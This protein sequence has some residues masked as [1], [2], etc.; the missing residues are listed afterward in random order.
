MTL[1]EPAFVKRIEHDLNGYS[2]EANAILDLCLGKA[3]V[4]NGSG[5]IDFTLVAASGP[6]FAVRHLGPSVL[7]LQRGALRIQS[8]V[9]Q[10]GLPTGG[11]PKDGEPWPVFLVEIGAH[12][13]GLLASGHVTFFTN[14]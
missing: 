5:V 8:A 7:V 11:N 4:W 6:D 2:T 14:P 9:D 13:R 12:G 3:A 10:R 1:P